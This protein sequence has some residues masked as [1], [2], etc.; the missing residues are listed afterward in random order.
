M[1]GGAALV[2]AAFAAAA[3][4]L[5]APSLAAPFFSDDLHYVEANAYVHSLDVDNVLAIWSPSSPVVGRVE[6]YAPV[7]LTLHA[8]AWQLFAEDVR[9]H[10]ALNVAL[11]ALASLLLAAWLRRCA[12]DERLAIGLGAVFL[13]HPAN[14]EAVAWISQLKTPAALALALAALLALRDRPRTALACF[15]LALLAKPTAAAALPV[16]AATLALDR[17]RAGDAAPPLARDPRARW[18]ALWALA[19]VAFAAAELTAYFATAGSGARPE[20]DLLVRLRTIV[21]VGAR[22][23]AMI[24]TGAGLAL[25]HD[26]EPARSWTNAYWL[27][28]LGWLAFAGFRA[29]A[30]ART[31][32]NEFVGWVFA[33]ASF[34]PVCGAIAL[35]HP[36]AD[37]YVYFLLPGLLCAVGVALTRARIARAPALLAVCGA[38]IALFGAQAFERTRMWADPELLLAHSEARYPNGEVAL[39]RAARRAAAAGDVEAA[40]G[41]V[42]AA[43]ARG[44]DR[45]DALLADPAYRALRG[46]ARFDALVRDLALGLI[47]RARARGARAQSDLRVIGQA[48]WILGE[49]ASALESLRAAAAQPGPDRDAIEREIDALELE[50]RL[51]AERARR[52]GRGS[53]GS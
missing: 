5:Y 41:G 50:Q 20:A 52:A 46:D 39:L 3:F 49:R 36:V 11:H 28:G 2:A 47:E 44:Y 1:R 35:P 42:R 31:R 12:V 10:H 21:A 32:S 22:Y 37:R 51:E 16:A 4:A 26:P 30:S 45:L 25:F 27:A 43:M 18:L 48:Q 13:V 29:L 15:A 40:V 14:V 33:G 34:V 24:A 7:H 8:I 6:N 9:G 19:F 53:P 17:A 38:A 23:V